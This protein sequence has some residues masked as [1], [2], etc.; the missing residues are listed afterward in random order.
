MTAEYGAGRESAPQSQKGPRVKYALEHLK[1]GTNI[2][3]IGCNNGWFLDLVD[4]EKRWG[5]DSVESFG[6]KVIA[7]GHKFVPSWSWSLPFE[8]SCFHRIHFGQVLAHM[9][10]DL[11]VK[12]LQEIY[13][14]LAYNGRAVVST[15]VGPNFTSGLVYAKTKR[16][17]TIFISNIHIIEWEPPELGDLLLDIGFLPTAMGIMNQE[18]EKSETFKDFRF[19]QSYVLTKA[20]KSEDDKIETNK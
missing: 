17:Y 14:V 2:L 7:K 13:R 8:D 3:D 11:G 19:V 9:R 5:L 20:K 12:S 16:V 18:E 1:G 6:E 15:V 10:P 4:H